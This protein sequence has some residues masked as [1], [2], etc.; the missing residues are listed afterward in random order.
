MGLFTWARATYQQQC[1]Q[2]SLALPPL[3]AIT[4]FGCFPTKDEP[5]GPSSIHI[6]ILWAWNVQVFFIHAASAA[7]NRCVQGPHH[8]QKPTFPSSSPYPPAPTSLL[9]TLPQCSTSDSSTAEHRGHIHLELSLYV[10]LCT[11]QDPHC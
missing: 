9:L 3:G 2:R 7:V 1:P 11:D 4:P 8:V 5:Q 6:G 10:S